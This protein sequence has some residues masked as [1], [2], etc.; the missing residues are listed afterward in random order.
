MVETTRKIRA[1]A[2]VGRRRPALT[3]WRPELLP[4][5]VAAAGSGQCRAAVVDKGALGGNPPDDI[6]GA[7]Y[8]R[9]PRHHLE[10]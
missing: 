8:R 3:P 2:A 9:H 6:L 4:S 7:Q 1:Q 5:T 10:T